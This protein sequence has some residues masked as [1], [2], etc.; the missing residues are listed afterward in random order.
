MDTAIP[1]IATAF[2]A[3]IGGLLMAIEEG[4]SFLNSGIFWRGFLST[5]TG[6]LTL[7]FL[8]LFHDDPREAFTARYGLWRDLGWVPMSLVSSGA[9]ELLDVNT[10][11]T[12]LVILGPA[13]HHRL[14]CSSFIS[15]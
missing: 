4:S 6:V 15:H 7:Q 1:G 11:D 9:R 13:F 12:V 14:L 10:R 3:P 2:A 5:C 8:A